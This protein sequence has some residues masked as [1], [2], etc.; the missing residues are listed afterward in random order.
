[1]TGYMVSVTP[2]NDY[3]DGIDGFACLDEDSQYA[4]IC[5]DGDDTGIFDVMISGIPLSFGDTVYVKVEY[6]PWASKDTPVSGPTIVSNTVYSVSDGAITV[7]VDITSPFYGYRVYISPT[8][9]ITFVDNKTKIAPSVFELNQNYPNPF[10]PITNIE[11]SIPVSSR[12]SLNVYNSYGQI[13]AILFE[14]Y[15]K[16]GTHVAEFNASGLTS[17]VYI[18]RLES[19]NAYLAKKFILMK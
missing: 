13:V 12:I 11:Y 18:Y 3:S 7:P 1:M 8:R 16:A 5:L 2:P 9:T 19:G 10:N 14:G 6:V 15:Q 17:G 4:S